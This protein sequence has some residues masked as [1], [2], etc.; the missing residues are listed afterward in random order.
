MT[1]LTIV[2]SLAIEVSTKALQGAKSI[3]NF[4]FSAVNKAGKTVSEASAKIKK[5][6]EENRL[7]A[8]D[9]MKAAIIQ[10]D[11][12]SAL[13]LVGS[14]SGHEGYRQVGSLLQFNV[15]FPAPCA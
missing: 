8:K 12:S 7:P 9:A 1:L 4:L 2:L 13:R 15:T 10:R 3:G 14:V 5:T 6:V 11:I